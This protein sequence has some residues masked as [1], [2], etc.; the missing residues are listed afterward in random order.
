MRVI[1]SLLCPAR[2]IGCLRWLVGVVDWLVGVVDWLVG[3]ADWLVRVVDWNTGC[4]SIGCDW[5]ERYGIIFGTIH[6]EFKSYH[7]QLR[8]FSRTSLTFYNGI[9]GSVFNRQKNVRACM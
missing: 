5:C 2:V 9:I 8:T 6:A 4:H 1:L 3:V 7:S